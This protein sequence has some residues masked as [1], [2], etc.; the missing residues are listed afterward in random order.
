LIDDAL[1]DL[2]IGYGLVSIGAGDGHILNLCIHPERQRQGLGSHLL[3]YL[4][5]AARIE[6]A[7]SVFLEVRL[8]NTHAFKLYQNL[9][10]T[11]IGNRKGYYEH[12][13]GREDA[14]VLE[15]VFS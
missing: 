9:G 15:F 3:K 1:K 14:I 13:N 4:L 2:I 5:N 12:A 8:S 11:V 6:G 10:F 7:L